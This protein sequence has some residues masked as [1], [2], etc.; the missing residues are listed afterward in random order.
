MDELREQLEELKCAKESLEIEL[1]SVNEENEELKQ[2]IQESLLRGEKEDLYTDLRDEFDHVKEE[3]SILNFQLSTLKTEKAEHLDQISSLTIRL[4]ELEKEASQIPTLTD[5]LDEA[6]NTISKL[7]EEVTSLKAYFATNN[8]EEQAKRLETMEKTRITIEESEALRKEVET[9]KQENAELKA[10]SERAH[11]LEKSLCEFKEKQEE[12]EKMLAIKT[13]ESLHLQLQVNEIEKLLENQERTAQEY[14]DIKAENERMVKRVRIFRQKLEETLDQNGILI[15]QIKDYREQTKE[16]TN[17]QIKNMELEEEA[18]KWTALGEEKDKKIQELETKMLEMEKMF[19]KATRV[20]TARIA[21][22]TEENDRLCEMNEELT[23]TVEKQ[24]DLREAVIEEQTNKEAK[25]ELL[26]QMNSE[27]RKKVQILEAMANPGG[28]G[29]L[30]EDIVKLTLDI[31][32]KEDIILALKHENDDLNSM[33]ELSA[34][35]ICKFQCIINEI[36]NTLALMS[37]QNQELK[38]EGNEMKK[39]IKAAEQENKE[40]R[41]R[42]DALESMDAVSF[43]DQEKERLFDENDTLKR[44]LSGLRGEMAMIVSYKS[45]IDALTSQLERA[46]QRNAELEAQ[47]R[48]GKVLD[49]SVDV[50]VTGND[51]NDLLTN[52]ENAEVVQVDEDELC[53]VEANEGEPQVSSDE[54]IQTA[55]KISELLKEEIERNKQLERQLEE[56]AIDRD[57]ERRKAE[58]TTAGLKY[59][60]EKMA[61]EMDRLKLENEKLSSQVEGLQKA[62]DMYSGH[63]S[64]VKELFK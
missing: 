62:A 61:S 53:D 22:M 47:L 59:Q 31:R 9:I 52:Y 27:L 64:D 57:S 5:Q 30:S 33:C 21:A 56:V 13:R 25:M 7:T 38:K 32:Q 8:T 16:M 2:K 24:N 20:M 39:T 28:D 36:K 1:A 19:E 63:L 17:L 42:I 35:Q 6:K 44:Q 37:Q 46:E 58:S 50:V 3:N 41:E 55:E 26:K 11:V 29:S 12:I 23:E 14:I 49:E 4:E 51:Q 60:V 40:L 45:R 54:M 43:I 15:N 18:K 48:Q 34:E 10:D